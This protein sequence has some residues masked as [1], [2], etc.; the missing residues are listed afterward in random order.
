[1][2]D[3]SDGAP[4]PPP[5]PPVNGVPPIRTGLFIGRVRSSVAGAAE[6]RQVSGAPA[7]ARAPL[8]ALAAHFTHVT[9]AGGSG[10]KQRFSGAQ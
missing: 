7:G 2:R 1:M 10:G 9:V 3:S 5:T 4:A 8:A 6:R